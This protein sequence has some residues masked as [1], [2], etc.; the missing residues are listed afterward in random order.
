ME[1]YREYLSEDLALVQEHIESVFQ[2]QGKLM[3]EVA[4]FLLQS[5]GKMLRPA[6]T[7][8][9]A[10]GFGY[11]TS[12]GHHAR[13]GAALEIFHLATLLHDDVIDKAAVRRGRPTVNARWSDEVAILFADYL[14]ASCFDL[15]LAALDPKV[16]QLLTQTTRTMTEGEMFQ[17]ERRGAWLTVDDYFSIIRSKTAYLFSA[18]SAIGAI[19][20][21]QSPGTIQRMAEFGLNFGL[22]FQITDDTLDYEAQNDSWGKRVGADLNE[23]KQTLPLLHALQN[24]TENDRSAML[25]VLANGRDFETIHGFVKQYNGIDYSLERAGEFTRA[26]ASILSQYP[27]NEPFS[28][29]QRLNEGVLVRQF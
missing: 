15:A 27:D 29:L 3:G 17:I 26:A 10:R 9:V 2:V 24:A 21:D 19:L 11:D 25:S 28:I 1:L 16:V 7:C 23:G 6:V 18:C 8:L 4:D 22:A 5:R 13:I 14:Y 20:A 12:K